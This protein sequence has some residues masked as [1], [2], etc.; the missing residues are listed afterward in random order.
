[1]KHSGYNYTTSIWSR[2]LGAN[3]AVLQ[4]L[5][6]ARS[7]NMSTRSRHCF[8]LLA[9]KKF[10]ESS[11]RSII[12]LSKRSWRLCYVWNWTLYIL[13]IL[14]HIIL[15]SNILLASHIFSFYILCNKNANNLFFPKADEIEDL[16][17]SE[18]RIEKLNYEILQDPSLYYI[19]LVT[20]S[21]LV[22]TCSFKKVSSDCGLY[23][24]E[25]WC[26]YYCFHA[27]YREFCLADC[28]LHFWLKRE[29][30]KFTRIYI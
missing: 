14:Y 29:V 5:V 4:A 28:N 12:A 23:L 17:K 8:V 19:L 16:L 6:I 10:S 26:V 22:D 7:N 13:H 1:M 3:P 27:I 21:I 20:Y 24:L 25:I 18:D 11:I 30:E 9:P 15:T 2:D